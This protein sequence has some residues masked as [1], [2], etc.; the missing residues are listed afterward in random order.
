[1][2]RS[3]R[4]LNDNKKFET[5]IF[6]S[7]YEIKTI[8]QRF[9]LI[10]KEFQ[11][12]SVNSSIFGCISEYI[13]FNTKL[14]LGVKFCCN[15]EFEMSS[16][17]LN[18]AVIFVCRDKKSLKF[19]LKNFKFHFSKKLKFEI[20]FW[21]KSHQSDY[22]NKHLLSY[23]LWNFSEPWKIARKSVLNSI[24]NFTFPDNFMK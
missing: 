9:I 4:K 23:F 24:I 14:C 19:F 7:K 2:W 6:F 22:Y 18:I 17:M 10:T 13:Q 3:F 5:L 20:K 15:A 11:F 21:K 1:M 8:V 12:V 16:R